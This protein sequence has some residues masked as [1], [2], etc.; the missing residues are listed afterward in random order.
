[1]AKCYLVYVHKTWNK[2]FVSYCYFPFFFFFFFFMDVF[3]YYFDFVLVYDFKFTLQNTLASL[4][5]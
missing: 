1:M 2:K 5:K 4:I 3:R